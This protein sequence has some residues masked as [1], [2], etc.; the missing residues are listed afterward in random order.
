VA[1]AVAAGVAVPVA[2]T[3]GRGDAQ[4]TT[5]EAAPSQLEMRTS[6]LMAEG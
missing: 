1:V 2:V 5:K 6:V 4:L 3:G